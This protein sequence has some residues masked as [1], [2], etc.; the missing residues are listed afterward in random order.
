MVREREERE[1]IRLI[2]EAE[3]AARKEEEAKAKK[4][5]DERREAE[6][7]RKQEEERKA[8]EERRF[9]LAVE[10][11]VQRRLCPPPLIAVDTQT[12][13]FIEPPTFILPR[14]PITLPLATGK[15]NN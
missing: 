8:A 1:R 3:E 11:E 15:N 12:D 7:Q 5:Q 6:W 14:A 4:L 9:Q 13:P 10:K 2:R